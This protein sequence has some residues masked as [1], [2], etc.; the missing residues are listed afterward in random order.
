MGEASEQFPKKNRILKRDRFRHVYEQGRKIH[1]KYFTAFVLKGSDHDARVGITVTRKVGD[2]VQRNRARRLVREAFR[3]NKW[4][5]PS[6][7]DIVINVKRPLVD[8]RYND[9]EGD[10][11]GFLERV[12]EK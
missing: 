8:A 2:S 11:I 5:A 7:V 12:S 6:G 1:T 3:R 4:L 9:L 10:F